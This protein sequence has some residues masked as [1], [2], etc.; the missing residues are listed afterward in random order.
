A[1][2]A[3]A[4]GLAVVV[5]WIGALGRLPGIAAT[6]GAALAAAGRGAGAI[7]VGAG[8]IGAGFGALTAL[9]FARWL[10]LAIVITAGHEV[11]V[12]RTGAALIALLGVA[13]A[14]VPSA[15]VR[16]I[17]PATTGVRRHLIA[18]G[19]GAPLVGV[20]VLVGATLRVED[21]GATP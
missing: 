6:P 16:V 10:A 14:I 15:I 19:A 4:L 2:V 9:P 3:V 5:L 11:L 8:L 21:P 18:L 12:G 13:T 17:A 1:A 7:V 20:A